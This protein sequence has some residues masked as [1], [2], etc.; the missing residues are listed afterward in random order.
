MSHKK[1]RLAIHRIATISSFNRREGQGQG[2]LK[3]E[4]GEEDIYAHSTARQKHATNPRTLYNPKVKRL[5]SDDRIRLLAQRK[6]AAITK[7]VVKDVAELGNAR[8]DC[9]DRVE[10]GDELPETA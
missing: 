3:Q 10:A 6:D 5:K 1:Q 7:T 2:W 9:P 4:I 8:G